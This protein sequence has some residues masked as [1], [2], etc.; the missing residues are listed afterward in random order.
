MHVNFSLQVQC[1]LRYS[2]RNIVLILSAK[3]FCLAIFLVIV[4]AFSPGG[5][6][7]AAYLNNRRFYILKSRENSYTGSNNVSINGFSF[8]FHPFELLF[9][10]WTASTELVSGSGTVEKTIFSFNTRSKV[11]STERSQI[12]PH[13][14]G[15][16]KK[17][18]KMN[19]KFREMANE[20]CFVHDALIIDYQRERTDSK[21]EFNF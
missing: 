12:R 9:P 8:N 4:F 10:P 16:L 15:E 19:K 7:W 2:W 11:A 21:S 14:I 17:R 1:G 5:I 13:T 3:F 20:K 18:R 6:F